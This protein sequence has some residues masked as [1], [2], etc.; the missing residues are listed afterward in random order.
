[1]FVPGGE[2][3]RGLAPV[4]LGVEVR[5]HLE[6]VL[7]SGDLTDFRRVVQWRAPQLVRLVEKR[8]HRLQVQTTMFAAMK[9]L[10]W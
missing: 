3:E 6:Q 10:K 4:V 2:V 7:Y 5:A 1:M 9:A 8:L